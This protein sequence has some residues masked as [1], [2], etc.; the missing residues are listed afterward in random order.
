M[1]YGA[2]V[3][4]CFALLGAQVIFLPSLDLFLIGVVLTVFFYN[5][6]DAVFFAIVAGLFRDMF[7]PFFGFHLLLYPIIALAGCAAIRTFITHR[8][9]GGFIGFSLLSIMSAQC[10]QIFFSAILSV[11]VHD[12]SII[13]F[14]APEFLSL[15]SDSAT[16]FGFSL[17]G[18]VSIEKLH[19]NGRYSILIEGV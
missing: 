9:A 11:V 8:S 19:H 7:Y 18:F 1:R 3:L 14:G 15:I 12:P 16:L 4:L 13:R 5:D 17:L 10:M 6:A 2:L